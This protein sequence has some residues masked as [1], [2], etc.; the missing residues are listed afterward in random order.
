MMNRLSILELD[1]VFGVFS[2]FE[3]MVNDSRWKGVI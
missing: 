1:F 2:I 3:K